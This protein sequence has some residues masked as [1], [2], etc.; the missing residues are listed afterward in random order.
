MGAER[1]GAAAL[2]PQPDRVTLVKREVGKG[3]N[4]AP[5]EGCETRALAIQ[6]RERKKKHIHIVGGIDV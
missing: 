2:P 6:R 3:P 4:M 1:S 5:F